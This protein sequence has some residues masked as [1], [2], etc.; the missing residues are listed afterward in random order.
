MCGEGFQRRSPPPPSPH[1]P[2]NTD[3]QSPPTLDPPSSPLSMTS[4]FSFPSSTFV[5]FSPAVQ[6]QKRHRRKFYMLSSR[7]FDLKI[8]IEMGFFVYGL[9]KKLCTGICYNVCTGCNIFLL[10]PRA[11]EIIISFG[12]REGKASL[13]SFSFAFSRGP[14]LSFLGSLAVLLRYATPSHAP[15]YRNS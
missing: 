6:Q 5:S 15:W 13:S 1:P 4:T 12:H 7:L 3:G 10:F 8:V 9:L 11:D 14:H 2:R